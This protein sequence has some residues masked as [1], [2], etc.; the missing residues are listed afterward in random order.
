MDREK[1]FSA[2]AFKSGI[3]EPQEIDKIKVRTKWREEGEQPKRKARRFSQ[4]VRLVTQRCSIRVRER[5]I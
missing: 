2:Q 4:R 1:I 3:M 5:M